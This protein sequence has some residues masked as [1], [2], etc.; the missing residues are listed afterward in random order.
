MAKQT[1][2]N[3]DIESGVVVSESTPLLEDD[4]SMGSVRS[5][6]LLP[7][8]KIRAHCIKT[9]G[10]IETVPTKEALSKGR[11]T[12]KPSSYWID[13]DANHREE[14]D[15]ELKEWLEQLK[16]SR[17]VMGRLAEPSETW[18]SSVLVLPQ[19]VLAMIQ[20][21]PDQQ[22]SD[23]I[24]HLA[25]YLMGNILLTF[26]S[27][28]RQETGGQYANVLHYIHHREKL[29]AASAT[30]VLVTWLLYHLERTSRCMRELRTVVLQMDEKMDQDIKSVDFIDVINVKDQLLRLLSVAEEQVECLEAL[31]GAE[32]GSDVLSFENMRGTMGVLQATATATERMG[33]RIEKQIVELRQRY[34]TYQHD[35]MNRR[36]AVLTVL[37]AVFLP[38]TLLTGIWGMNFTNMPELQHQDAYPIAL[39]F[40]L[41]LAVTMVYFF[42]RHGWF[43]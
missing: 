2:K 26:T 33:L 22:D 34:E 36:L 37:S 4:N 28:D 12:K 9:D 42:W 41:G 13:V 40:M 24:T 8:M 20:I 16:L 35:N 7:G 17:F 5:I 10:T 6:K 32:T 18:T 27:C 25:V 19:S 39:T 15:E 38:L 11:S 14:A 30:G 1:L 21:L 31:V 23:E 29:P 3:G 43:T